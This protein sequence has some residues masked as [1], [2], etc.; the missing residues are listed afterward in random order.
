M[1]RLAKQREIPKH[2]DEAYG[3]DVCLRCWRVWFV[4]ILFFDIAAL[5]WMLTWNKANFSSE[6]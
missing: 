6:I 4:S 2:Y 3:M 1:D 5:R